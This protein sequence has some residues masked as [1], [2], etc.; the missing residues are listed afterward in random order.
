[1]NIFYQ[2]LIILF[3]FKHVTYSHLPSILHPDLMHYSPFIQRKD[4]IGIKLILKIRIS[5]CPRV[6][7]GEIYRKKEGEIKKENSPNLSIG[8]KLLVLIRP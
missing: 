4:D 7:G 2:F 5:L 1:M 6:Y 8:I 3:L